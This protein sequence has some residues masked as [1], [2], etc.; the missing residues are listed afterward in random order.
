MLSCPATPAGDRADR[1]RLPPL[2]A[3]RRDH[4]AAEQRQGSAQGRRCGRL[5]GVEYSHERPWRAGAAIAIARRRPQRRLSLS[6]SEVRW[7]Q[8]VDLANHP[9][10]KGNANLVPGGSPG[11]QAV[12]R[13][14]RPTSAANWCDCDSKVTPKDDGEPC[15][16]TSVTAIEGR[17]VAALGIYYWHRAY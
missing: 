5:R 15:Y 6:E 17:L 4:E 1:Y 12:R 14:A 9:A 8:M 13:A 3:L 2:L 11:L 16:P 7:L 10:P